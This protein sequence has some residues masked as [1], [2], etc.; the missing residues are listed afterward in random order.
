MNRNTKRIV[1]NA[2]F[3]AVFF[4]LGLISLDLGFMKITFTGLPVIISGLLFGPVD[5][6]IVGLLGSFLEQMLKHGFTATTIL[7]II[8]AGVRGLIMGF[9]AVK[10]K[11]NYTSLGMTSMI[12]LSALAVTTI[13][14]LVWYID[15][16]IYHYYSFEVVFGSAV[17]RYVTGIVT[18]VIF[19]VI[20]PFILNRINRAIKDKN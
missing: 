13:N 11:R 17:L 18:A 16:L 5:G 7:W 15:S 20:T 3:A 12:V 10:C 8:P 4:V 1:T 2:M 19:S 14:T 6:F 9:Y